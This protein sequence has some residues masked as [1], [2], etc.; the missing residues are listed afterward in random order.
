MGEGIVYWYIRSLQF[1]K[2]ALRTEESPHSAITWQDTFLQREVVLGHNE[3]PAWL[4]RVRKAQSRWVHLFV[5]PSPM[6]RFPAW[7]G[8]L[9][10]LI[11]PASLLT[12]SLIMLIRLS[13]VLPDTGESGASASVQPCSAVY[14]LN[15]WACSAQPHESVPVAVRPAQVLPAVSLYVLSSIP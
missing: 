6:Q 14:P 2:A 3:I 10:R 12:S 11:S 8:A 5:H 7:Q 1:K 13:R 4:Q 15:A 9:L